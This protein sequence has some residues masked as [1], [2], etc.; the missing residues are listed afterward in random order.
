MFKAFFALAAASLLAASPAF[1]LTEA[2]AIAHNKLAE[3]LTDRGIKL[4][5]D[6]A[7]CKGGGLAGFYHSP[8][9]SLVIC[10]KGSA[11]MTAANLN[12]LRHETIHIIQ[13]CKVG[14]L[15]DQRLGSVYNPTAIKNLAK[16]HNLDL[17]AIAA[18]YSARGA[19]AQV[20]SLE[21]EAWTASVAYNAD[22]IRT[23]LEQTCRL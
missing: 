20:V 13:D 22:Q 17:P 21:Y 2:D 4:Y 12:T 6:A 7:D 11:K 9:R 1:A 15:G 3:A 19:N 23:K 8:S 18:A 5:T 14:G 16:S 10:N